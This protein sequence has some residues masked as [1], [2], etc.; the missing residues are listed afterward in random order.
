MALSSEEFINLLEKMIDKK[1]SKPFKLG[2]VDPA[3]STGLP[4]IVFDGETTASLKGY[5][6]LSS[7]KPVANDRIIMAYISNTYVILGKVGS[8]SGGTGGGGANGVGLV[9]NWNGT[10]LGV[11]R[12][13][14]TNYTYVDLKGSTGSAGPQGVK[15][16]KGDKGDT[17]SAGPPGNTGPAGP[18]GPKGDTG[19]QGP[20][21]PAFS[22]DLLTLSL[23]SGTT[24]GGGRTPQYGKSGNVVV[25]QG[26]ITQ[27]TGV[28]ATLPVGYRPPI[29]QIFPVAFATSVWHTP[30]MMLVSST[31]D[32]EILFLGKEASG[33][34]LT[35]ASTARNIHLNCSFI[36]TE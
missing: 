34:G 17:G 32:V 12:E 29:S 13:T 25:I 28:I 14:D 26:A 23:S 21:G 5:T 9:Y 10:S 33:T 1:T 22:G 35:T 19:P 7:Y 36:T 27:K 2:K 30:S 24:V 20:Q 8:Y 6:H 11:K 3:Y 16:D 15:G 31:G 4:K 18:Q